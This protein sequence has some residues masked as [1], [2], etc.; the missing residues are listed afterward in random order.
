MS[1]KSLA[2]ALYNPP[3]VAEGQA[4]PCLSAGE[5]KTIGYG[6]KADL[7]FVFGVIG[8]QISDLGYLKLFYSNRYLD[9]LHI[10]RDAL[11]SPEKAMDHLRGVFKVTSPRP[12]LQNSL[13]SMPSGQAAQHL[14][15]LRFPILQTTTD[16]VMKL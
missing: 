11:F 14:G 2:D 7:A 1:D 9:L 3:T 16:R 8:S 5:S 6:S 15:V 10:R 13:S 4:T 12:Q